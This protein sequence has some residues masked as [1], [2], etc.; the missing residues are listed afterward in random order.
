MSTSGH[1][2]HFFFERRKKRK[3]CENKPFP[4]YPHGMQGGGDFARRLNFFCNVQSVPTMTVFVSAMYL[5][6][7]SRYS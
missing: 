2:C 1:R 5:L 4:R 7:F 3:K 6:P